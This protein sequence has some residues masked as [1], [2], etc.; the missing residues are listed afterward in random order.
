MSLEDIAQAVVQGRAAQ[1]KVMTEA[2]LRH[3]LSPRQIIDEGLYPGMTEVIRQ[4]K[5]GAIFIPEV[6]LASRA[7]Q[8]GL[9]VLTPVMA[10]TA[11]QTSGTVVIGT[12][13]E[14]MHDIGKNLVIALLK[15]AGLRV[16]DLGTN[17]Y[18]TRFVEAVKAEAPDV[19]AL[20]CLLTTTMPNM[21]RTIKAI[22]DA[23]LREK[24]K[25]IVGGAPVSAGFAAEV[26]ADGYAP[27]A[28]EAIELVKG[29][30][31]GAGA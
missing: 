30:V 20:S 9:D 11:I 5:K 13:F 7:M 22:K 31:R 2:A 16:I 25:V 4:M 27:S 3:K 19:L 14:D 23:G 24:V 21:R 29:L 8:A 1:V 6:L 10:N 26:G 28:E 17:V 18:P 15:G 12:V